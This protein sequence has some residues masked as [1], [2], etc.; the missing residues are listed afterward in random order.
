MRWLDC[1]NNAPAPAQLQG[2]VRRY[3]DGDAQVV[4]DQ[5]LDA[6]ATGGRVADPAP[7]IQVL[8]AMRMRWRDAARSSSDTAF[9][10]PGLN[11]R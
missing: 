11:G 10:L 4:I 7:L 6:V 3:G 5:L 9:V 1:I 8:T 2:F